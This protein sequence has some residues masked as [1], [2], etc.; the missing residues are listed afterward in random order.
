MN[1]GT[2]T[3]DMSPHFEEALPTDSLVSGEYAA[4]DLVYWPPKNS[5][6]IFYANDG[7][8]FERQ[9]LGHIVS[10]YEIFEDA[11][12]MEVTIELAG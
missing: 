7:S 6:A 11:G 2:N 1:M 10:E 9:N 3:D 8:S 5:L 12:D 4:G